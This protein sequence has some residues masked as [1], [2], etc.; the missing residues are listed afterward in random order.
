MTKLPDVKMNKVCSGFGIE[1]GNDLVEVCDETNELI[2]ALCS[3]YVGGIADAHVAFVNLE[4]MESVWCVPKVG[5]MGSQISRVVAKYL[6]E[7]PEELHFRAS[8]LVV[9]ALTEAF[10]CE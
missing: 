8:L 10:P 1:T 4:I 6:K 9:L 3:S 7:H 2:L 5:I